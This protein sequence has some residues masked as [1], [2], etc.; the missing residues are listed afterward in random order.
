MG[1][2]KNFTFNEMIKSNTAVRLG[3]PNIPNIAE[4]ANLTRLCVCGLQLIRDR[5]GALKV[6]SGFRSVALCEAVGSSKSSFQNL[7][8][9]S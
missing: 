4:A 8:M 1:L 9:L 6:S 3:I 5:L 7:R 2:S